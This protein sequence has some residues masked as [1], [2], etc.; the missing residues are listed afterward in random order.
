MGES[1]A[2][3]LATHS[4]R[5][6]WEQLARA[7]NLARMRRVRTQKTAFFNVVVHGQPTYTTYQIFHITV[8]SFDVID[9]GYNATASDS[10]LVPSFVVQ[11]NV[12][13]VTTFLPAPK[14]VRSAFASRLFD[15]PEKQGA[16]LYGAY[17]FHAN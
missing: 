5:K 6:K 1:P 2:P 10:I 8:R 3:C 13:I 4:L 12:S 7:E 17:E 11:Y 14:S 15:Q 16:R 9:L